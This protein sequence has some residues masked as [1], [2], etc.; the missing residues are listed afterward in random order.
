M[1]TVGFTVLTFASIPYLDKLAGFPDV[2]A[3]AV[4]YT[5]IVA[6][7][8][9]KGAAVWMTGSNT[10]YWYDM[11]LEIPNAYFVKV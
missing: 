8:L 1:Q 6:G 4:G 9:F 7:F 11:T 3:K 10:Y 5:M 2:A